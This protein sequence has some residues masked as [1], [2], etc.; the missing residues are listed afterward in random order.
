MIIGSGYSAAKV[1]FVGDVGSEADA[2]S[3][4]ALSSTT[5]SSFIEGNCRSAKI[6]LGEVYRTLFIKE[7][8]NLTDPES[9]EKLI[10][11]EYKEI[12]RQEIDTLQPNI[13]VPLS[14]LGFKF[15]SGIK[16]GIRKYRGSV[17]PTQAG[18]RIVR[19]IPVLGPNPYINLDPRM[20]F[21]SRLDFQKIAK[22][23]EQVG[24]IPEDGLLWI[25]KN[26]NSLETFVTR[27]YPKCK[28]LVFDI[29]SY[30]GI[31]TCISLCFDGH[32]SVTVPFTDKEIPLSETVAMMDLVAKVLGGKLPKVNQSIKY[33]W[34]KLVRWG[35]P[36]NN[37]VGDTQIAASCLYPEFPK[38][39][40][41]LTSIYT[42]MPYHKDEGKE[43][44]PQHH[45]R[46]RLYLYCAKDSLAVHR[47]YP[48]QMDEMREVNTLG[49]YNMLMGIYPIYHNM[50][51]TGILVDD[52]TRRDKEAKYWSHYEI[53]L[54]K[55]SKL[56]GKSIYALVGKKGSLSDT[57]IRNLVYNE[58]EYKEIR[59]IKKSSKT[60]SLGVDEESLEI[61]IF[62]H[63]HKNADHL[64]ALK[65][66][67]NIRKLKKVL[68][69]LGTEIHPDGRMRSEFNLAGAE[70]GRTTAG[71][72]TDCKLVIIDG[73]IKIVN[74]G[75]SFQTIAK[76]G[77]E[78]DGETYG[79]DIRE[80]FVPSSGFC[81][82]ECDLSQA[83]ARVDAVLARDF[84]IIPVFDSK[85]G[86]HRLTG[87][88][89]FE[90]EPEEIK[91]NILVDGIDRYHASKTVRH[92]AERNMTAERL[93]MMI[94]QPIQ[95]CVKVLSKFHTNQPNIQGVFHREIREAIQ[96]YRSLT[97]PD[98]R[99]RD[100]FGIRGG[101]VDKDTVNKGISQLPQA[102]VTDYLKNGLR[103][104]FDTC[105]DFARPLAE[106]HDGW[107]SEV[108]IDR[109]EEYAVEFV[110]NTQANPIDF[111]HCTLS[112]DFLLTIPVETE[113][114]PDNWKLMRSLKD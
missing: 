74:M 52:T 91:K 63:P 14:E 10:T 42:D 1:M 47:I 104:T 43:Y 111:K 58:L 37:V 38:N 2:L 101:N 60:G 30:C 36:V 6:N 80:M 76:H 78:I 29:E 32:E 23:I 84:D 49:V 3:G 113:W 24:P 99:K 96:K 107:L 25:A 71:V 77:F 44:D 89:V 17:L 27:S 33:D 61:L 13:I 21:I 98:G 106:A 73:K 35:I 72:T 64:E 86:I 69:F 59:G 100:F 85:T 81:F 93:M 22:N 26:Y 87:S 67:I 48:Q 28:F 82:V 46:S 83:E 66:I 34:R 109:K 54:L 19:C 75:H 51:T 62:R 39:L 7:R 20:A 16:G 18:N 53:Q 94:H 105:G 88:W 65:T 50:E 97:A 55:L 9:N 11:P 5:D 112:R 110:K 15:I 108:L 79:K 103:R 8:G 45:D 31:P 95:F 70:T 57:K 68:E 56:V 41:F 114:S 4:R 90:C 12:L 102:I 40:G 92:A